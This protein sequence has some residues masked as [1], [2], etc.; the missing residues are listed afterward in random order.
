MSEVANEAWDVNRRV[1][2]VLAAPYA[3]VLRRDEDG[4]SAEVLEFPG[5][6]LGRAGRAPAPGRAWRRPWRCG[7]NRSWSR[8]RTS[9]RRC[10]TGRYQG[11]ISL[12]VLPSVARAR[13][14]WVARRR[15]GLAQTAWLSAG[16]VESA[17]GGRGCPAGRR[18]VSGPAY[19]AA[20]IRRICRGS[21]G[22]RL[23]PRRHLLQGPPQP[24]AFPRSQR[25]WSSPLRAADVLPDLGR[26]RQE[27]GTSPRGSPSTTGRR[28]PA[29]VP[30]TPPAGSSPAPSAPRLS[31]AWGSARPAGRG[32]RR[33]C[34]RPR[35]SSPGPPRRPPPRASS[36][37]KRW[38]PATSAAP[39]RRPCCRCSPRPRSSM[40]GSTARAA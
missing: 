19:G 24:G 2:E 26:W 18:R 14:R 37:R 13:P 25:S 20:P 34:R 12:R 32:T 16:A 40:C 9:R 15:G 11:R 6:L 27:S 38:P 33:G 28:R 30:A 1:A 22:R 31:A 36:P 39:P 35:R 8:D 21:L 4:V 17:V 23:V 7:W 5:L 29:P 10:A 3:R